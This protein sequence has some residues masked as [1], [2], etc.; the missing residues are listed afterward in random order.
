[1]PVPVAVSDMLS[2]EGIPAGAEL[3]LA[4]WDVRVLTE[5]PGEENN[6]GRS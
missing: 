1:M 5:Q 2:G 3:D 6:Q 4:A